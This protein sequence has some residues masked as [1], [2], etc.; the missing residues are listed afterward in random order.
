[1]RIAICGDCVINN[2][3][4]HFISDRLLKIIDDNDVKAI[5]F[6]VPVDTD[7]SSPIHKSGP[8]L[9]QSRETPQWLESYGFNLITLANNH[10]LDYGE[11]GLKNTINSFKKSKLTGIGTYNTAYDITI[12]EKGKEKIGFFGLTHREF[13]CVDCHDGN[14]LGT[15]MISSPKVPLMIAKQKNEVDRLY[16]LPHAGVEYTD[17]PLPEWRELY[18]SFIALG[19][20]GVIASHPHVPQ[21]W[22]IY[23]DCPIFYSLGNFAFEKPREMRPEWYKSYIITIDTSSNSFDVFPVI[24][25]FKLKSIDIDSNRDR[26]GNIEYLN[27]L[28]EDENAY[29]LYIEQMYSKF[30]LQYEYMQKSGGAIPLSFNEKIKN[31]L[32]KAL[33][34]KISTP[35]KA[36]LLNL[37]QCESHRWMMM[38]YLK[39]SESNS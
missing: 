24:Y 5:N 39:D 36:N 1:M 22:E 17:A 18:R 4:E 23:N 28:L 14:K 9:Y 37:F 25:D 27:R 20:D 3:C 16:I 31:L 32:K 8:V 19:A 7:L 6:E 33:G 26:E 21:G 12:V 35:D 34:R 13:G 15:A 2:P 11:K 38:Q 10:S 30:K 29:N